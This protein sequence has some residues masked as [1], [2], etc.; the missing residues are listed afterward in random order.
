MPQPT[1]QLLRRFEF[2]LLSL[3]LAITA[4]SVVLLGWRMYSN[5]HGFRSLSGRAYTEVRTVADGEFEVTSLDVE[6]CVARDSAV[7]YTVYL[8]PE[9]GLGGMA[10]NS[11]ASFR[12]KGCLT[13]DIVTYLSPDTPPGAYF[14]MGVDVAVPSQGGHTQTLFWRTATF[15]VP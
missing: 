2:A 4:V 7:T 5:E 6:R 8:M 13:R 12:K 3:G 9:S 10:I 1:Y 14:L 15:L 11:G